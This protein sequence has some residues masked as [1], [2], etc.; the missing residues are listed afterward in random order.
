[1]KYPCPCCGYKTIDSDGHY[2]ICP[3]C[4]W[5]DFTHKGPNKR[6]NDLTQYR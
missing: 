5:E 1:M 6:E 2:H 4:F 3:I